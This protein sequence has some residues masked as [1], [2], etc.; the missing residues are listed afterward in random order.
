[1]TLVS[2]FNGAHASRAP[3]PAVIVRRI[4]ASFRQPDVR[5]GTSNRRHVAR[6]YDLPAYD[7]L[8]IALPVKRRLIDRSIGA[9]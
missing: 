1:M 7:P 2:T 8:A 4:P 3:A 9:A 6:E 5:Q